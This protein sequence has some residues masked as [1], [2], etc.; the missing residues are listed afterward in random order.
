MESIGNHI[1][2]LEEKS[3]IESAKK[4]IKAFKP[5]YD[6]YYDE[7]YR[8]IYR[9]TG[10]EHLSA[11]LSSETFY[12][13][14]ENIKKYEWR[15]LPFGNWLYTIASNVIKKHF[16]EKSKVFIIELDKIQ[17]QVQNDEYVKKAGNEELIWV[18]NQLSDLE[19]RLVE[20]KFFEE[21]TF[22]EIALLLEMKESAVKMRLYRLLL[23]M[24]NLI[25]KKD[26]EV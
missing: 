13:A 16:R 12:K 23:A 24:R 4:D 20:L 7:I 22:K 17:L 19:L 21:K 14:L 18:L 8:F 9:R 2:L 15:N 26:D 10:K 1:D 3:W 6:R 11:D 5:L 25:D